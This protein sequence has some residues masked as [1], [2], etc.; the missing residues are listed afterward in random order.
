MSQSKH[1]NS[2]PA[3]L[4]YENTKN[5]FLKG[6]ENNLKRETWKQKGMKNNKEVN[7]KANK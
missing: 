7:M 6:E 5:T 2:S 3:G 4:Q 1:K